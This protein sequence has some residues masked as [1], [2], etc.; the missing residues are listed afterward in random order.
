M[1]AGVAS[2]S[3]HTWVDARLTRFD[4]FARS[5]TVVCRDDV[6]P[7]RA[8]PRP[9]FYLEALRGLAANRMKPSRLKIRST[10][11]VRQN[12]PGCFVRL[13]PTWSPQSLIFRRPTWCW[14]RSAMS[15]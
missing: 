5:E 14:A 3:S 1:I 9:D 8:K 10:V 2:S 15:R 13:R 11:C 6:A 7:G 12:A 4:L